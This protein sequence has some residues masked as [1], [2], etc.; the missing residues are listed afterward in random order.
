MRGVDADLGQR[1]PGGRISDI[2]QGRAGG[3]AYSFFA[4]LREDE[5]LLHR[6]GAAHRAQR[7]DEGHAGAGRSFIKGGEEDPGGLGPADRLEG[8]R[9]R[10]GQLLV[11]EVAG[12]GL[13]GLGPAGELDLGDEERGDVL[14]PAR[15]D[16]GEQGLDETEPFGLRSRP[17]HMNG[18]AVHGEPGRRVVGAAG[19]LDAG[20]R[21][22]ESGRAQAEDLG[23]QGVLDG[24]GSGREALEDGRDPGLEVPG[25]GRY[26]LARGGKNED[27]G[28]G[29][30]NDP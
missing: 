1:G 21:L 12:Q 23:A 19:R 6:S 18:Q 27:G 2:G 29:D 14:V 4:A 7:V 28:E 24:G 22:G 26:G 20:Q 15:R 5:E 9:D 11:R 10:P 30:G 25:P 8:G 3:A 13:D 16:S 17:G